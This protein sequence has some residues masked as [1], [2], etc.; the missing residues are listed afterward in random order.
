MN[1][2]GN[3]NQ[4]RLPMSTS[5]NRALIS[6]TVVID[7]T[8]FVRVVTFMFPLNVHAVLKCFWANHLYFFNFDRSVMTRLL[9]LR[10]MNRTITGRGSSS[11]ALRAKTCGLFFYRLTLDCPSSTR[12]MLTHR[13]IHRAI[14]TVLSDS[15]CTV[16]LPV[17]EYSVSSPETYIFEAPINGQHFL[18]QWQSSYDYISWLV[19]I[20]NYFLVDYGDWKINSSFRTKWCCVSAQIRKIERQKTIPVWFHCDLSRKCAGIFFSPFG[21]SAPKSLYSLTIHIEHCF[22]ANKFSW[23]LRLPPTSYLCV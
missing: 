19:N 9:S 12:T 21:P 1:T 23:Q 15:K 18:Q 7:F 4:F 3:C 14:K 13:H 17:N 16:Q 6:S 22:K 2:V 8:T 11:L 10:V 20:W 5:G